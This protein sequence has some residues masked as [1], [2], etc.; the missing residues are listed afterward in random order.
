MLGLR[1]RD[2]EDSLNL[3]DLAAMF[4]N[5]KVR[6]WGQVGDLT[7]LMNG[8]H[9]PCLRDYDGARGWQQLVRGVR[10]AEHSDRKRR[11]NVTTVKHLKSLYL[12]TALV[13]TALVKKNECQEGRSR[14][15]NKPSE[16]RERS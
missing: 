4:G 9:C 3:T 5:A 6:P 11:G 2:L 10:N 8:A 16:K 1:L 12:R 14:A 13:R 7:L 15:P